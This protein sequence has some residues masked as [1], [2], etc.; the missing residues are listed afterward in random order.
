[1]SACEG[2]SREQPHTVRLLLALAIWLGGL[3]EVLLDLA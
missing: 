1:L 2:D 3:L